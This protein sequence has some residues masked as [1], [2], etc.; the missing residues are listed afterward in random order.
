MRCLSK[1]SVIA[2][3]F[4]W[5]GCKSSKSIKPISI[6]ISKTPARAKNLP[7]RPSRTLKCDLVHTELAVSFDWGK[8]Y[9]YGKATLTLKPHFYPQNTL[10]L[11]AKGFDIHYVRLAETGKDLRYTYDKKVISIELDRTYTSDKP[12]RVEIK[13]TAKPNELPLGG[14][15]AI[16]SDKGLFFINADGK[17][18]LK[19]KQIWTQGEVESSSCWFPTIDAPNQKTTQEIQ[20]TV[21]DKYVTLSNGLLVKTM[22]NADG[23]RTDTWKQDK[24]HAP[25]LVMMAVGDFAIV[26]EKMPL[27]KQFDWKGLEVSYFVEPK[28]Q[29]HA[30]A[31]FGNTPEMIEFFSSKLNYPYAWDKYAQIVVRDYVSGAMENSSAT[32]LMEAVQSTSREL[33]DKHWDDIIAHELFHHWFGDLVTCEEW[34]QLPL[35]ESFA[36]Y[37]EFLWEE[38]KYGADAADDHA[39][40]ELEQYLSESISKQEPM[41]RYQYKSP[42]DMFDNHSYAKGGRILHM[43]RKY[44][45]DDAFFQS[46]HLYLKRKEFSASEI[47]DLRMAFEQV[48]G[49]DFNWFFNQW[50]LS[51]G[52]PNLEVV[53]AYTGGKLKL[54]LKQTQ[55]TAY[56][57]LYRLP[58]K[59]G[60]WSAGK[61]QVMDV[62]LTKAVQ[63][64]E[65]AFPDS[66]DLVVVDDEAQLLGV[67]EHQKTLKEYAYQY[68][69]AKYYRQRQ[70]ALEGLMSHADHP[71]SIK[72]IR[73]GLNDPYLE[74]RKTAIEFFDLLRKLADKETV[75][76]VTSLASAD[77][78]GSVRAAAIQFLSKEEADHSSL[79]L[80]ALKDSSYLVQSAALKSYLS[81]KAADEEK[82]K[83]I[84]LFETSENS[85]I[86]V[87]LGEYY[88][89]KKVI[90]KNGWFKQNIAKLGG[91]DLF[92][93]MEK[94]GLYLPN[95]TDAEK[96]ESIAILEKIARDHPVDWIRFG[97]FR[98]LSKL[99]E[100]KELRNEIRSKEHSERL[101][102]AYK[103][104]D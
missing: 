97:A 84:T 73:N 95:A 63:S 36:N 7:N 80:A 62:T 74:I 57:P 11:D 100:T 103:R 70:K 104:F 90:G 76:K 2:L 64:F 20:M 29:R 40:K 59:V 91:E 33:L 49:E 26:K 79:F 22:K 42:E 81:S 82:T 18:T 50:F 92:Q 25:Y 65:W 16:N 96:K 10:Q 27:S 69:N 52:H 45:G 23:T 6:G 13:Y 15:A 87:T 24:P 28:Y 61:K 41:I 53:Q 101:K 86:L 34:G 78:K 98:A 44:V 83:Q 85:D 31:I 68:E 4:L 8:Q 5:V 43:L 94:W 102:A 89:Q 9:L 93:F 56:T 21:E 55:D 75:D 35:N 46:L 58:L 12:F 66:V 54:T 88:E 14:N 48:T 51:S 72:T 60:V 67:I 71:L 39:Q 19:P 38:H 47:H 1:L 37:S 3:L 17:D 32:V 30:K 99:P 77:P